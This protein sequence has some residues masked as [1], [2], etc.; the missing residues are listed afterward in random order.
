MLTEEDRD[1]LA[2]ILY[3]A[4]AGFG[5]GVG[6]WEEAKRDYPL[7]AEAWHRAAEAAVQ[8]IV[9]VKIGGSDHDCARG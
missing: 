9:V 5:L 1:K 6:C 8:S 2:G 7:I 4:Y 3:A